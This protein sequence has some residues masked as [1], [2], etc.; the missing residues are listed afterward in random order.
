[1]DQTLKMQRDISTPELGKKLRLVFAPLASLRLTVVMFALSIFLVFAGTLAQADQSIQEVVDQYFRTIFAWIPFQILF[2]AAFFS[3]EPPQIPGGFYFPGGFL[4]G[5]V[6]GVNLLAAHLIRFKVQARGWSLLLGTA[7]IFIGSMLVALV[8][9]GGGLDADMEGPQVSDWGSVWL[10][11]KLIVAVIAFCGLCSVGFF[12]L[13][14]HYRSRVYWILS[15][16]VLIVGT[17]VLWVLLGGNE[18]YLGDAG[19]RILWQLML[20]TGAS[21]VCLAGCLL[22]FKKRGGVVLLHAGLALLMANELVVFGLHDESQMHIREGQTVQYARDIRAVEL[23]FVN[24]DGAETDEVIV[25]P[26]S[27]LKQSNRRIENEFLPF[28]LQVIDYQPNSELKRSDSNTDNPATTGIGQR[29]L[30][31]PRKSSSGVDTDGQVDLPAAYI[32]LFDKANQKPL[33]TYL[34]SSFFEMLDRPIPPQK[35]K[36]GGKTYNVSLRFK[37][38]YKPYSLKLLD[39]RFDKYLGTQTAKNYSSELQL[40]DASRNVDRNVKVWMNNPLRYS[41]D[42]LY[43]SSFTPDERGTIL[44]VV[45]N[46]GWMLPYVACMIVATGLLAHFSIALTRFLRRHGTEPNGKSRFGLLPDGQHSKTAM[47]FFPLAVVALA[48]VLIGYAASSAWPTKSDSGTADVDAFASLPIIY[49]GRVKPFDTLALNSLRIIAEKASYKDVDGKRQP[50]QR[51]LLETIAHTPASL[52][53]RIFRFENPDLLHTLALTRREG[54]RYSY[55]ELLPQLDTFKQQ[56]ALARKA[57]KKDLTLYQK[58]ILELNNKIE[59]FLALRE[60]HRV[61]DPKDNETARLPSLALIAAELAQSKAPR[62]IPSPSSERQWVTLMT[63]LTANQLLE[64]ASDQKVESVNALASTI[65]ADI[66]SDENFDQLVQSNIISLIEQIVQSRNPDLSPKEIEQVALR[67]AANLPE[68][69]RAS[70]E[71]VARKQVAESRGRVETELAESIKKIVGGTALGEKNNALADQMARAL[72]AYREGNA[73]AFDEAVISY[74]DMLGKQNPIELAGSDSFSQRIIKSTFGS[75]YAFEAWFNRLDAFFVAKVLYVLIFLIGAVGLL[76]WHRP[77]Q[78]AA[79]WLLVLTFTL[80]TIALLARMYISGRP[81]VTNLYSSAV[82][83]G[84]GCVLLAIIL[85]LIYRMGIGT[86]VGSVVGFLTLLVAYFLAADG[87]TFVV[88]QAVLDTQ[89]WLATHVVAITLGYSTTFLAGGL[90]ILYILFLLADRLG[91]TFPDN[92]RDALPRMIYGVLCFAIFFSF[93]GTVLGGLWADDSWGRFWGWDPKENGALIIVLWNAL[94]L[95]AR[96]AGLVRT[97]GLAVLVVAGNIVTAWSWFGVNE[98][99]VGLHSYGF[100]EGVLRN[101][102][103]VVLSQ[104]LIIGIGCLPLDKRPKDTTASVT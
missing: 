35:I 28:D 104:L 98:L 24:Q 54:F 64:F 16:P 71:P 18:T 42:T 11:F 4:I 82:F 32:Q 83:I 74:Q 78:R 6:M 63:A 70:I 37:R 103:I 66:F 85:E 80:H 81:P 1:M 91:F 9:A 17:V 84:W 62:A 97:R 10:L 14:G 45:T 92:L 99:G 12:A 94:V 7:L 50:Y 65:V 19:M 76:G 29:L 48:T 86:L 87:D 88:L 56:V 22:V 15:V 73:I 27:L 95:H 21:V 58:K 38:T 31:V 69:M 101:L 47:V 53:F 96:W 61:P 77:L 25:V 93:V 100:K 90:G 49:Q 59:L 39:F 23:A 30:S 40:V 55:N 89:F 33:G 43:Q 5:S 75:F 3:G 34:F 67:A 79:F 41:G 68:E 102:L 8:I 44:Q 20:A 46:T 26:Q 2:P 60:S 51:W 57:D 52:D 36:S 72:T 13:R